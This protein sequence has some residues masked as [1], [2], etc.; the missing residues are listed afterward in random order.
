MS[1]T[2]RLLLTPV[3]FACGLALSTP[4]AAAEVYEYANPAAACQLSIPTTDTQ[5]RPKATGFRNES[6]TNGA[7]VICGYGKPTS[8][9]M[10]MT[11]IILT[12]VSADGATRSVSCTAVSSVN[13]ANTQKYSTKT[14]V[15][16]A[17]NPANVVWSPA[18]FGYTNEIPFTPLP[19]ATCSLPPQI[20]ITQ[21]IDAYNP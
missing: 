4:S 6:T 18:D 5:V 13:G 9:S 17:A 8:S 21:V 7:F 19:S 20:A 10:G 12:L 16:T 15:V 11:Q 1:T 2:A 14:V 3:A